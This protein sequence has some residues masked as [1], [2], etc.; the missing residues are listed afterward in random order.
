MDREAL[1]Q[2]LRLS[3]ITIRRRCRDAIVGRDAATGRVLYDV[4]RA[5][6]HVEAV[7]GRPERRKLA[8][9]YS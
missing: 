7:T 1:A 3:E 8:A 9:D 6:I 4:D 2:Y 5:L